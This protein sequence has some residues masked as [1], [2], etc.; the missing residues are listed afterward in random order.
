[1]VLAGFSFT[2]DFLPEADAYVYKYLYNTGWPA[3]ADYD[4]YMFG[5]SYV[6]ANYYSYIAKSCLGDDKVVQALI[7]APAMNYAYLWNSFAYDGYVDGNYI[8]KQSLFSY[9]WNDAGYRTY[10]Y[11]Y[12]MCSYT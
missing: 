6:D 8:Y 11:T 1:M 10:Y 12:I 2:T 5:Y 9:V 4:Y 3:Y 7:Y